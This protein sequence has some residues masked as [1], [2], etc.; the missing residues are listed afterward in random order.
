M[1]AYPNLRARYSKGALKLRRPLRLPDGT[2]VR[3]SVSTLSPKAKKRR[4]SKRRL[5]Y[6]SRPLPMHHLDRL[7]GI[8]SLGGD[9]L[10]DSEA[11]YD[12]Q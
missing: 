8:M 1:A 9:A 7:A 11:L 4:V 10:A 2:E 5:A 12:G 3:V 6:P